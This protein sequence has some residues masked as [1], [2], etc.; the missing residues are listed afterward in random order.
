MDHAV[1][2]PMQLLW[3]GEAWPVN[4]VPVAVTPSSFRCTRPAA[5]RLGRRWARAIRSWDIDARV[6]VLGTGGLS[7]Q[8][9]GQRAGFINKDFDQQFMDSLVQDPTWATRFTTHE[10]V[11]KAGTQGV[12]AADVAGHPRRAGRQRPLPA[13]GT[14]TCRSR[15]RPPRPDAVRSGLSEPQS[16]TGSS[17]S[18]FASPSPRPSG[19]YAHQQRRHFFQRLRAGH[20]RSAP[21]RNA[22]PMRCAMR[23]PFRVVDPRVDAAVRDDLDRVIGQQQVDQHAVVVLGVPDAQ[24]AEQRDR[25]LARRG[26]AHR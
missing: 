23:G 11:E 3:P 5:V 7:H 26:A 21:S 2:L 25:A 24:L 22:A 20:P 19:K 15:T 1:T 10:L 18:S 12:G 14:T 4:V 6:V 17:G 16:T 13:P 8:L 9:D